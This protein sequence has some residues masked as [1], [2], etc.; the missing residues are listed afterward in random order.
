[1]TTTTTPHDALALLGLPGLTLADEGTHLQWATSTQSQALGKGDVAALAFSALAA[2][3]FVDVPF[4]DVRHGTLGRLDAAISS[5]A[6]GVIRLSAPADLDLH[7]HVPAG[8]AR[9]EVQYVPEEDAGTAY[10]D[11]ARA[12]A[13]IVRAGAD[14]VLLRLTN[15]GVSVHGV[16]PPEACLSPLQ[17]MPSVETWAG[18]CRDGWLAEQVAPLATSGDP[19]T[20]VVAAGMLARLATPA[21]AT[22]ARAWLADVRAGR[23]DASVVA[24][25]RW[26]ASLSADDRAALSRQAVAECASLCLDIEDVE[27]DVHASA[28]GWDDEVRALAHRR[29]DLE[30]VLVLLDAAS[31]ADDLRLALVEVDRAGFLLGL[32]IPHGSGLQDERLRRAGLKDPGAWWALAA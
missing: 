6:L 18:A 10:V 4:A 11:L 1:M 17:S 5:P 16:T 29:D 13:V 21:D 25:R 27:D 15:D 7:V 31:A 32:A 19:W 30:A 24:P 20:H 22:E 9:D 3:G 14:A 26:A 12:A 23:A 8:V 2:T 28:P